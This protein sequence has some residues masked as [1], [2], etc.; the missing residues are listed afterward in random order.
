[1]SEHTSERIVLARLPSGIEVA[2]TVHTY[3]GSNSGPTLYVQAAQ[4]GREVNGTEV[5]RRL[6]DRLEPATLSGTLIAI[7]VANPLT[8]DQVSY[9]TSESLD[10]VNA[11]MNRVWPGNSNGSLHERM[12]ARLWEFASGADAVIDLHTGSPSTLTHVVFE[13]GD[14]AS[15]NLATVFGTDLLLGEPAEDDAGEE[16]AVRGFSGKFRVTAAKSEIPSITPELAQSKQLIEPAIRTGVAG[17]L[18]VLR[19]L[20]MLKG[21][22]ESNGNPILARNHLSRIVAADSGLFQTDPAIELGQKISTG[23]RLGTLYAPTTYEKLQTVEADRNGVLYS[24]TQEA[25]VIEG[26][27]LASVA[28]KHR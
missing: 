22:P 15:R 9:T 1:M 4:H 23:N 12:V 24:L 3:T 21:E 7:P 5:L 2:T 20:T 11:N 8:F 17:I 19:Y 6:H 10:A 14:H 25:T 27:T 28:I 16:W 18:N 26:E 13:E